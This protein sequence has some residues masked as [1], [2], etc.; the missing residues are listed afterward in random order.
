MRDQCI[1]AQVNPSATKITVSSADSGIEQPLA[2]SS[3]SNDGD[4]RRTAQGKVSVW[5][6]VQRSERAKRQASKDTE[7]AVSGLQVQCTC[8][9]IESYNIW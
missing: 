8:S 7:E 9:C 2:L 4:Q 6:S 3:V 5:S 1:L